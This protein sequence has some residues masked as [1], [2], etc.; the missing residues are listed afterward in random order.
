[1]KLSLTFGKRLWLLVL[2]MILGLAVAAGLGALLRLVL[3]GN[4]TAAL[5]I[6]AVAQN[7]LAFVIPAAVAAL[8]VTRLPAELLAIRRGPQ[9]GGLLLSLGIIVVSVPAIN[10]VTQA[11]GLLPWPDSVLETEAAAE[12]AVTTM[13]GGPTVPDLIVDLLIIGLLTGLGEELFFRG[14]LQRLLLSR[15]MSIHAAVW[16]AAGLFS[17]MH[18]QPVGFVSRM[19]LGAMMGYIAAWTA[20]TWTA[21]AAHAMNNSLVVLVVWAGWN[22]DF[23]GLDT[24][25]LSALSAVATLAGMWLLRR[26]S[27]G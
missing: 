20:S 10:C 9:W 2:L 27:Q 8:M 13:M 11:C 1:M 4:A 5:R 23:V 25:L 26:L 6:S 14:A 18:G 22:P 17:L 19:L 7:L 3:A 16:I 15:P 21:V 12:A 24:P